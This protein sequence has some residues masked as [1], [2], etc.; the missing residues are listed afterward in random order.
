MYS[1]VVKCLPS[2]HQA[3]ERGKEPAAKNT[4]AFFRKDS[5]EDRRVGL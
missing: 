1:P 3:L 2:L 5:W 4:A